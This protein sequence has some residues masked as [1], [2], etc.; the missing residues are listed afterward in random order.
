[1]V[2]GDEENGP[3]ENACAS[4]Y[5]EAYYRNHLGE[6]PYHRKEQHWLDFFGAVADRIV[7]DIDRV[8]PGFG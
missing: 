3:L 4:S 7:T 1:M 5:D 6:L 8:C 2:E